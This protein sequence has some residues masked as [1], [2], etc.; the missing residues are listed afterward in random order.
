MSDRG[1]Q[2][3]K[4]DLGPIPRAS[5]TTVDNDAKKG[6]GR[7]GGHYEISVKVIGRL[8]HMINTCAPHS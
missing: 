5:Q 7:D 3:R 2:L 1:F 4:L 6:S 8:H